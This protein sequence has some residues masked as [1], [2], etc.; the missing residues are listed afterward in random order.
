VF[1][2]VMLWSRVDALLKLCSPFLKG[3]NSAL[4]AAIASGFFHK[5]IIAH[6]NN[7][8]PNGPNRKKWD[9]ITKIW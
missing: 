3:G 4:I 1:K 8:G 7:Y 6:S 2:G 5:V 9:L